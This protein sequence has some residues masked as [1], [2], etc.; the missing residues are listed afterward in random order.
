MTGLGPGRDAESL[1][2]QQSFDIRRRAPLGDDAAP[3]RDV[4]GAASDDFKGCPFHERGA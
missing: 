1:G 3:F 2:L 4:V